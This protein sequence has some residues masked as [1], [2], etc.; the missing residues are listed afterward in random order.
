[1]T[2][3]LYGIQGT[4]NGHLAR[5]RALVNELRN[6]GLKLDFVL[7]GRAPEDNFDIELFSDFKTY[8]VCLW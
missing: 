3:I 4:G 5:A 6:A 7:T 1:M 2:R 8:S